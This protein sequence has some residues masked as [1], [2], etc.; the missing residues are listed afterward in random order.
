MKKLK[1]KF[2]LFSLLAITATSF[3][4]SCEQ[5]TFVDLP[6]PAMDETSISSRNSRTLAGSNAIVPNLCD[7]MIFNSIL[8]ACKGNFEREEEGGYSVQLTEADLSTVVYNTIANAESFR[9]P[10][11]TTLSAQDV[12]EIFCVSGTICNLGAY[13]FTQREIAVN[14]LSASDISTPPSACFELLSGYSV[15]VN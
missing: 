3:L 9:I 5:S 15:C 8:Q 1:A 14:I 6:D 4:T 7:E 10:V 2:I 13:T 12:Q 11:N